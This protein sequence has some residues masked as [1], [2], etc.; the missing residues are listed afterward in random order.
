MRSRTLSGLDAARLYALVGVTEHDALL[1]S[2]SSKFQYGLWRPVT[3]IRE[4]ERDGN[5]A[6]AADPGWLALIPTP[7]Y[8]TYP[9]NYACLASSVTRVYQRVFGRDDIPFSVTWTEAN[10]PGWTRN[11]ARFTQVAEEAAMS[12][13]WGGIHFDFDTQ[14]GFAG[15]LPVAEYIYNNAFR[16]ITPQ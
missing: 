4:A 5:A 6:T 16:R 9:G 11:Y 8:P 15:C 3:A 10:G 2:F 14:A 1:T 7:P 13:V 12:R